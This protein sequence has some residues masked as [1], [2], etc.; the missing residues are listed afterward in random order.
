MAYKTNSYKALNSKLDDCVAYMKNDD[1]WHHSIGNMLLLRS[2]AIAEKAHAHVEKLDPT[3]FSPKE[4]MPFS[5]LFTDLMYEATVKS[6]ER[7]LREID[8]S[9]FALLTEET[10]IHISSDVQFSLFE[11]R[12]FEG[13]INNEDLLSDY[14]KFEL[15]F[16]YLSDDEMDA[17]FKRI[18]NL[19]FKLYKGLNIPN[20]EELL[21]ETEI[22]PRVEGRF[23]KMESRRLPG[24]RIGEPATFRDP[25]WAT[26]GASGSMKEAIELFYAFEELSPEMVLNSVKKTA[27]RYKEA[28]ITRA[29]TN[30]CM[31]VIFR[32]NAPFWE[33]FA[34]RNPGVIRKHVH[35]I[36]LITDVECNAGDAYIAKLAVETNV[37]TIVEDYHGRAMELDSETKTCIA[38]T[39]YERIN[40]AII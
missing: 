32:L 23:S 34:E 30:R 3:K 13:V 25:G 6:V 4:R 11:P 38:R 28:A 7:C 12:G 33:S 8:N 14:L 9:K 22:R 16:A 27:L 31:D 36:I 20:N 1:E 2:H 24:R 19:I 15:K 39:K 18:H 26:D 40:S 17:R 5:R 37:L 21:M 35:S 10:L 29:E